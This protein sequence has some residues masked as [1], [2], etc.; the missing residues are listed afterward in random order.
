MTRDLGSGARIVAGV[1]FDASEQVVAYHVLPDAPGTAFATFGETLRIPALEILH[2][3]DPIFPGQVRGV[4]WLAPV[5][6]KLADYDAASD[7]MLMNLKTQSLFAG[8][9][10]DIKGG[11][12]GFEGMAQAGVTNVSLELG[13]M[14]ILP[15]GSD[16]EIC[17]AVRRAVAASG[18]HQVAAARDRCWAGADV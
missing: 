7:A 11:A 16:V 18:L 4:T 6:L 15:P 13:A 14:H 9:I 1:K 5:L 8:F 3:F 12:A 10:T 17:S 2:I